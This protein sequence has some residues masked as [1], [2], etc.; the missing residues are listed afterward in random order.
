MSAVQVWTNYIFIL[1]PVPQMFYMIINFKT[2]ACH[3]LVKKKNL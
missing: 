2:V 1:K 3:I